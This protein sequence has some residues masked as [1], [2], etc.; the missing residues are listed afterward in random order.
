[1]VFAF[2]FI[3]CTIMILVAKLY[4]QGLLMLEPC[5]LCAMQRFFVIGTALV[6]AVAFIH[7]PGILGR[8]IYAVLA[9]LPNFSGIVTASR[10]VWLQS[11]PIEKVP[12]C[13]P[14]IDYIMEVFSL[15]D[16]LQIIFSGSGECAEVQWTLLGLTIPGW[17]LVAFIAMMGVLWFQFLRKN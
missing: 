11:L 12:E 5:P 15:F 13:G 16:A 9:M 8:K 3:Y 10:H 17:T 2:I 7:N 14:G 6:V 4:F 1:M